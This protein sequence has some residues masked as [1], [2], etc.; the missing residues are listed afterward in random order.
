MRLDRGS[1]VSLIAGVALVLPISAQ[2]QFDRPQTDLLDFT[3]Y[4]FNTTSTETDQVPGGYGRFCGPQ[5]DH[6]CPHPSPLRLQAVARARPI[7]RDL[8]PQ[9]A[10]R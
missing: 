4:F 7:A 10:A 9:S 2:A 3:D 5:R 6:G 8:L 1:L